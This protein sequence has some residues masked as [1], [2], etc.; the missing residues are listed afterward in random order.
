[1][2]NF[3]LVISIIETVLIVFFAN[4]NSSILLDLNFNNLNLST[5]LFI[6]SIIIYL[7]GIICGVL[8]ML[9]AIFLES[10]KMTSAKRILEKQ[11]V[12]DDDNKLKIRALENKI[13][14]LEKALDKALNKDN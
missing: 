4:Q 1:M 10:K 5:N 12:N 6:F 11:S 3:F 9:K 7:L 13:Q 14:T 2:G 8:I